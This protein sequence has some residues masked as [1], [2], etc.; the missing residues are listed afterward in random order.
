MKRRLLLYRNANNSK[1]AEPSVQKFF[2][3]QGI[4][5][6]QI[7][8][9][10]NTEEALDSCKIYI[11]RNESPYNYMTFDQEEEAKRVVE[12]EKLAATKIE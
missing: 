9:D 8:I 7:S 12:V 10:K 11:E 4:S 5:N 1:V 2:E 3:Q 6:Y